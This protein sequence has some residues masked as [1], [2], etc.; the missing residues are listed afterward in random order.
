M[1]ASDDA[2]RARAGVSESAA[3][4]VIRRGAE[5]DAAMLAAI[6]RRTFHET[7]AAHNTPDDM[8]AY[9]AHAYGVEQQL[10]ELTLPDAWFLIAEVDGVAAAYA[11]LRHAPLPAHVTNP[12]PGPRA[13]PSRW[14]A[15]TSTRPG[16]GG[17]SPRR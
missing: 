2:V 9:L 10:A 3:T 5:S 11:Y 12:A 8:S 6:C 15:S 17:G 1:T 14:R 4:C 13:S 16:M 7:F